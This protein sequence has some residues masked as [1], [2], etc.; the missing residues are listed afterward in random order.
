MPYIYIYR[1]IG[2]GWCPY[3]YICNIYIYR[4]REREILGVYTYPYIYIYS[5]V[6]GAILIPLGSQSGWWPYTY[7]YI[8]IW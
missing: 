1:D 6:T 3:T 7:V 2:Y 8:D 5:K 4:E